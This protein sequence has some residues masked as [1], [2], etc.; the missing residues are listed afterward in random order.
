M[1]CS[2]K[3]NKEGHNIMP[4]QAIYNDQNIFAKILRGE[5]PAKIIYENKDVLAFHDVNPKAPVHVLVIPKGAYSSFY[6]FAQRASAD[7][8]VAM[9]TAIADLVDQLG[10]C[11]DGF[12]I[13]SNCG[14]HGGQE[15]PHYHVHLFGG[16][17]LGPMLVA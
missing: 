1:F 12:R 3:K 6:D 9:N 11:R 10:L 17:P 2:Y 8:A 15:V 4:H 7:E 5:I 16:K 14:L 13:L